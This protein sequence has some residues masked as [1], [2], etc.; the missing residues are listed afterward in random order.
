MIDYENLP[1]H[2]SM[3]VKMWIDDNYHW[4]REAYLWID[5][6][7]ESAVGKNFDDIYSK[8][9]ERF[10]K[11]N[12][13]GFRQV[14]KSYIDPY[15]RSRRHNDYYLDED[16]IIRKY[17]P[18]VKNK[19]KSY[20]LEINGITKTYYI[21]NPIRSKEYYEKRNA[22]R[23]AA[24]EYKAHLE[25]YHRQMLNTDKVIKEMNKYG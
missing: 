20:T 2:E 18:I 24:R 9:C 12:N 1:K 22:E 4:N 19:C 15:S 6:F 25:E 7:L 5:R 14:F 13:I 10:R 17:E 16:R 11:K 8:V 23:K 21:G 3:R